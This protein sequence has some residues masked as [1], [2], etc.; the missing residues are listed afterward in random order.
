MR[1]R[2]YCRVAL[3]PITLDLLEVKAHRIHSLKC[4]NL[5]NLQRPNP[6]QCPNARTL[7]CQ[8]DESLKANSVHS[9][10]PPPPAP[11]LPEIMFSLLIWKPWCP[12]NSCWDF[13]LVPRKANHH[14][15]ARAALPT[16]TSL[17]DK[18]QTL[19]PLTL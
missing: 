11:P 13:I 3:H 6:P 14:G 9:Y 7:Q 5:C 1:F 4:P 8:V 18:P 12:F 15:T 16:V 2:A 19:N 10:H 17:K